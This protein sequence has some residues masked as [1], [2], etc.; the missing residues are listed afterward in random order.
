MIFP[1][2]LAKFLSAGAVAQAATGAGVVVVVAHRRRRRRRPAGDHVQD[3]ITTSSRTADE[4]PTTPPATTTGRRAP[5]TT[6]TTRPR[7]DPGDGRRPGG[8][9]VG[10]PWSRTTRSAVAAKAWVEDGPAEGTSPSASGSARWRTTR[11]LRSRLR[12][13]RL[14]SVTWSATWAHKKGMRRQRSSVGAEGVDAR[15]ADRGA[16]HRAGTEAEQP[17]PR[18]SRGRR[19]ARSA[20]PSNGKAAATASNG[21]GNGNGEGN[22]GGQRQGQ[23][24]QLTARGGRREPAA[25]RQVTVAPPASSSATSSTVS[26]MTAGKASRRKRVDAGQGG[27][28]DGGDGERQADPARGRRR[29][30]GPGHQQRPTPRRA[31][32][33]PATADDPRAEAVRQAAH[34]GRQVV[35]EVGCDVGEVG[36]RAER[37]AGGDQPPGRRSASRARR[38][39]HRPAGPRNR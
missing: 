20:T 1:A 31:A 35:L 29:P 3:T 32:G 26:S 34:A 7:T 9:D 23:R 21:N 30:V 37:A 24:P 10:R 8:R 11:E 38:R 22:G 16:D 33:R 6:A 12:A 2:L 4:P 25:A 13:R 28:D 14:P 15:R 19:R 36:R 18:T 5:P 27:D 39:R 17:R